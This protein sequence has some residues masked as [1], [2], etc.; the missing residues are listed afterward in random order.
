MDGRDDSMHTR[1]ADKAALQSM[2]VRVLDMKQQLSKLK[3]ELTLHN[4]SAEI[5]EDEI[6]DARERR[7]LVLQNRRQAATMETKIEDLEK[8]IVIAGDEYDDAKTQYNEV[9]DDAVSVVSRS[10][11]HSKVGDWL[12]VNYVGQPPSQQ[13]QPP[14][15]VVA[16][17]IPPASLHQRPDDVMSIASEAQSSSVFESILE[18]QRQQQEINRQQLK[19]INSMQLPSVTLEP[20]D[21]DPMKYR[22]HC[23]FGDLSVQ[24]YS[25]RMTT[26]YS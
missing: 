21:G 11:V 13:G 15:S 12:A 25:T 18:T 1:M 7:K 10:R 3:R 22:T 20:F 2:K 8:H 23:L 14:Q 24:Y 6:D 26:V 9:H 16:A 19:I 17:E 5:A 4:L